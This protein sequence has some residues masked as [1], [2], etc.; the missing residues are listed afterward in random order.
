MDWIRLS[1]LAG[2]TTVVCFFLLS[3]ERENYQRVK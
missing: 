2:Y 1:S 3:F